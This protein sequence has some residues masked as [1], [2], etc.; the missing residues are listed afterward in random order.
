MLKKKERENSTFLEQTL[1][2][3]VSFKGCLRFCFILI[4]TFQVPFHVAVRLIIILE[5]HQS[6]LLILLD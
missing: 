1:C 6:T 3:N 5:C 2:L 4:G